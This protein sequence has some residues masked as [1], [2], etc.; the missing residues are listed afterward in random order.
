VMTNEGDDAQL[1]LDVAAEAE[2]LAQ[3]LGS[4]RAR[5]RAARANRG[6]Y[7]RSGR[8]RG[9][10][11]APRL[12][13]HG[14]RSTA[15]PAS[16]RTACSGAP[17]KAL[18][19]C[20]GMIALAFDGCSASPASRAS[21]RA[22]SPPHRPL[23]QATPLFTTSRS[24]HRRPG[25]RAKDHVAGRLWDGGTLTARAGRVRAAHRSALEIFGQSPDGVLIPAGVISG[26]ARY[27]RRFVRK[28]GGADRA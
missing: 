20:R 21:T 2:R 17:T 4:G 11:F 19:A 3:R 15:D 5:V 28:P 10:P 24:G 16:K 13:L 27:W 12:G 25:G 6:D 1:L 23:P 14:R 26:E 22:D 9:R 7:L 18:P 8:R